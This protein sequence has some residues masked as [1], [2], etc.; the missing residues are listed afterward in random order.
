MPA[1]SRPLAHRLLL[2][3]LPPGAALPPLVAD[4]ELS[5]ELYDCI[6]LGLRAFVV[7][8]WSKISRYDRQFLPQISHVLATVVRQFD[9]RIRAAPLPD[10]FLRHAPALLTQHYRDYRNAHH[11]L[12]TSYA[13][14]GAASLPQLFHQLQPHMAVSADGRLDTEYFRHLVDHILKVCLP[15]EDYQPDAER[16]ILREILLKVLLNDLIPKITQPWFIQKS[17]LDLLQLH[18][19]ASPRLVTYH[20]SSYLFFQSPEP[21]RCPSPPSSNGSSF[22]TIIVLVL[23]AI[24]VV[25]GAC[26]ALITAYK[27]T[28]STIKRVNKFH[29]TPP[30]PAFLP[31]SP[32]QHYADPP[33]TMLAEIFTLHQRTASTILLTTAHLVTDFSTSFLDRLLPHLLKHQLSP[34]FILSTTRTAKRTFFPNGYPGPPAIEPTPEEQAEIRARLIAW[35]PSGALASRLLPLLLG[36]GPSQTLDAALDPLSSAPCN[37]HLVLFLLDLVLLELFPELALPPST[38]E[39][40][41]QNQSQGTQSAAGRGSSVSGASV[42]VGT[43]RDVDSVAGSEM[44]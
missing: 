28:L 5:A 34:A 23:S 33:L 11:K 3:A 9:A 10:L 41:S 26:L 39:T 29:P 19:Q 6:A 40:Q 36:P 12:S 14:G 2:P 4:A 1:P 42:S 25:S 38:N 17:I 37:V 31:A 8:W 30:H 13:S 22:H 35:R 32:P 15:P 43:R 16:F 18:D 27:Q 24:Q 7:P 44:S 21:P 20:P